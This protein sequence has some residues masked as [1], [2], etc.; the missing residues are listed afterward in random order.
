MSKTKI[1]KKEI[2]NRFNIIYNYPY[3]YSLNIELPADYYNSTIQ[4][5]FDAWSIGNSI[6]VISGNDLMSN[7]LPLPDKAKKTIERAQKFIS[8]KIRQIG[9][10]PYLYKYKQKINKKVFKILLES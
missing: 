6:L 9:Y 1:T 5:N 2:N 8:K 10:F 3:N 7:A 4:W